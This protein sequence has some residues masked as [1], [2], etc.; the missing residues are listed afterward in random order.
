MSHVIEATLPHVEGD[1]KAKLTTVDKL[2][3]SHK[4]V[5]KVTSTLVRATA[6]CTRLSGWDETANPFPAPY[7][8]KWYKNEFTG[9]ME[10][11]IFATSIGRNHIRVWSIAK[12]EFAYRVL[13]QVLDVS[14]QKEAVDTVNA[15]IALSRKSLKNHEIVEVEGFSKSV[16]KSALNK[17]KES[18]QRA[19]IDDDGGAGQFVEIVL[20]EVNT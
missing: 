1:L 11:R 20:A 4:A 17:F 2:I 7:D 10:V 18:H 13:V 15:E 12:E 8:L 3:R 9:P 14:S 19:L 5:G 6:A 16:M